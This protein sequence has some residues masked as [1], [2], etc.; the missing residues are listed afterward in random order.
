MGYALRGNGGKDGI[1]AVVEATA[2]G[3]NRAAG[4]A[5]ELLMAGYDLVA[6]DGLEGVINNPALQEGVQ[7]FRNGKR[8]MVTCKSSNAGESQERTAGNASE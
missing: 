6:P 1:E 2:E 5:A 7:V 8:T 4:A 3:G